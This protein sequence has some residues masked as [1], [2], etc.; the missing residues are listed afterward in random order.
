MPD[1]DPLDFIPS[2][3]GLRFV[4]VVG[5]TC[6]VSYKPI[7][8]SWQA[9]RYAAVS[10]GFS[11]DAINHVDYLIPSTRHPQGC[12]QS[13]DNKRIHSNPGAGGN[14]MECK[15]SSLAGS[16]LSNTLNE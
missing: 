1:I 15:L 5:A 6:P 10:L 14:F 3:E 4:L 16:I 12:F 8:I 11:G 13:G 9:C 2:G 7:T